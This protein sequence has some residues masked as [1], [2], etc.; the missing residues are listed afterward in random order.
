MKSLRDIYKGSFFNK[1]WKLNWRA[2]YVCEAIRDILAPKRV[3]DV[4]CATGDLVK[5]FLELGVDAWGLEGS[6]NV[7]PF[8]EIP[9]DRFLLYDLRLPLYVGQYD[10][11]ICFEVLE[12]IEPEYADRLVRTLC[13]MSDRLLLSAAPPGCGGHYHV[14]CQFPDYWV[15][16]LKEYGYTLNLDIGERLKKAWA[17]WKSKPG[18]KAYYEHLLFFEK[19]IEPKRSGEISE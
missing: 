1:R 10:L 17:P 7:I 13:L 2:P 8:L 9:E 16:K 18:I 19:T 14:N 15:E 12:H 4:G 5:R 3:I 6:A 11:V